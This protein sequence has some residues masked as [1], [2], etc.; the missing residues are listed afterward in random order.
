MGKILSIYVE[1][2]GM[3]IC[4]IDKSG[5]TVVV[6]NAFEVP[7]ASGLVED[8]MILDVEET[9]KALYTA[10][11]NNKIKRGKIVFVISSKRIANKEIVIPFVKNAKKIEEIIAANVD[12]YFPMN[13]LEDY[14]FRHTVLDTLEDEEGKRLSIL[15]MAFQKQMVEEYY[16]LA[17][18][19][20]MPVITVDYY[21]NAMYQL[22]KKQLNQGTVL[23][24][25]MDRNTSNVSIMQG[26]TQLFKRSIPYGRETVIRN[27]SELKSITEE[28]AEDILSDP[29]KVDM[30]LTL[31]EYAEIIRDFSSSVTRMAE[32][33]TSR[34]PGV[35]IE[36]AKLMG[37][38]IDLVGFPEILAREL[39]VEVTLM[40]ELVGLKIAK[41]NPAGLDYDK[42]VDYLPCIGAL[43]EPL[44]LKVEEEKKS[45]GNY[46]VFIILIILATLSVGGT[47]GF[48]IWSVS[49]LEDQ[50]KDLQAK[51]D[52]YQTAEAT[53]NEY[54]TAKQNYDVINNYYNSTK[55]P[56]EM[57]YQMILD[58]EEVMPESVGIIDISIKNGAVEMTG[59]SDGKESLAKFVIELKKL[60][61]VIN[62]RVDDILDTNAELGGTTS[63]FN[64]KWQL[65]FPA[66]EAE[67]EQAADTESAAEEGGTQ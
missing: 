19:L 55:N 15:V 25:Q 33:H 52:S 44:N 22:L 46:T 63:N 30:M 26:K 53:Y 23:A 9:A 1:N 18:M 24:I 6:K 40:K 62:V 39:G 32:F 4:E 67:E 45:S 56:S 47:T 20:K 13:N 5:K 7:L 28:E 66:E 49:V 34:N 36:L 59:V 43:I 17:G 51:R 3:R 21:G 8:G 57:T 48:L 54:V 11:K 37:S 42:I 14:I 2:E 10:L 58:L 16:Q 50:K 61:Y 35:T 27:L 38:G 41:K 29:R 60:P 31:E 65:I 12:E 64:M